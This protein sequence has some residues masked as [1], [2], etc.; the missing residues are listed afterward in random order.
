MKDIT[1]QALVYRKL[2]W[3]VIPL[4]DIYIDPKDPS[5]KIIIY[6]R[7]WKKYQLHHA[8]EQ[9][10]VSWFENEGY[11]NIGIVTGKISNL[12]VLDADSYKPGF[13]KNLV[14]SL[15]LPI[16]PCQ[17]TARGGTQYF[18]HYSGDA[19]RNEVNAFK[20][21]SGLDI[22][23]NGGMCIVP[24]SKPE[25]GVYEW[26][27]S[28]SDE[29]LA[30]LPDSL[31]ERFGGRKP[32]KTLPELGNLKEGEGR[33]NAM[34][35]FIGKLARAFPIEAWPV[36]IWPLALQLNQTYTP[37][38]SR[39][40]MV[41]IYTS[42]TNKERERREKEGKEEKKEP[43][44]FIP[45]ISFAELMAKE[46]PQ[47]RFAIEP[48]FELGTLNMISAPPQHW[49]S[50][51]LF[52][53]AYSI[54]SGEQV[55]GRFNSEKLKV[56][57]VNEEDPERS[58]QARYKLLSMIN[59]DIP[60][61]FRIMLGAKMSAEYVDLLVKEAKEKQV[62]V[63]IFDSLRALHNADENDSTAMQ[64]ILDLFKRIA[65]AGITVL[66]SHHH[67]KKNVFQ[68]RAA[69]DDP[70]ASRGS[71]AINA[72]LSGHISS[73]EVIRDTG[74]YIIIRHLKSKAGEKLEPF[75]LKINISEDKT[76]VSF[77]Y[78]GEQK[79]MDRQ[80]SKA[81]ELILS[82]LESENRWISAKEFMGMEELS[83]RTVRTALKELEQEENILSST[84]KQLRET[85][86][87][88][89][90]EG[91]SNEKLYFINH[92]RDHQHEQQDDDW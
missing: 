19:A 9:E 30:E 36:E 39:E 91:R 1:N 52:I 92:E 32:H 80:L 16:T 38:L 59:P 63:I 70:E 49:K 20:R 61:Y 23:A 15:K 50:W 34:A 74:R 54:A 42:I 40:D 75:E 3:S 69:S 18:F 83:L 62:S 55:F 29:I 41:R 48:F 17:K 5:K 72:A 10:I 46:F 51:L 27:L 35:S 71:S 14:A 66:F 33:D 53:F 24:P 6:P 37:P 76:S 58:I 88:L 64:E 8:T 25:Y 22:R 89:T 77:T 21:D 60:L 11:E 86:V 84:R 90:T 67:R 79:T 45:A 56:M 78:D 57:I 73:E 87:V 26:L 85:H 31:K 65:Q 12:F 47:Q 2:G 7:A 44:K 28:P 43:P 81:K 68:T 82:V 13:D 4:G